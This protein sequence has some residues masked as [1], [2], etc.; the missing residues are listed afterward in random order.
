[1]HN[2]Y[3]F[4]HR[5]INAWLRINRIMSYKTTIIYAY[6]MY[7]IGKIDYKIDHY[8][9]QHLI[10]RWFFMTSITRRYT[11]SPETVMERDLTRLRDVP[12][13]DGIINVIT[14]LIDSSLMNDFWNINLYKLLE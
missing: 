9:L 1:I 11:S 13:T 12:S 10:A 6:I 8:Q 7:L 3:V 5:I 2:F 14:H 4:F